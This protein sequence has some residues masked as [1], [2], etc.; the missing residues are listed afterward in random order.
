MAKYD[1]HGRE[2]PDSTPVEIPLRFTKPLT[3][4]EE[5]RRM[6]RNEFSMMAQSQGMETFE[7]ADD[8]EVEDED[9]LMFVSP[10]EIKEMHDDGSNESIEG[11]SGPQDS[12]ANGDRSEA[13]DDGKVGKQTEK[14]TSGADGGKPGSPGPNGASGTDQER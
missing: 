7:E 9:E 5:M 11:P 14:P 6:L 10:Y 12:G 4:Q 2:I 3:L 8:F 13:Q 1:E